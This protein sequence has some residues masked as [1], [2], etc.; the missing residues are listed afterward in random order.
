MW[1]IIV[2]SIETRFIFIVYE[3]YPICKDA[4]TITLL[5]HPSLQVDTLARFLPLLTSQTMNLFSCIALLST[6]YSYVEGL[7]LGPI[8]SPQVTPPSCSISRRS[9]LQKASI[10]G[11]ASTGAGILTP[12]VANAADAQFVEVG[13]QEKP[14]DGQAPFSTLPNGVQVKEFKQG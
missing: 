7:S 14:P 8:S 6:G 10:F 3:A 11:V 9:I 4:F 1:K 13:Q 5:H 12:F 2:T